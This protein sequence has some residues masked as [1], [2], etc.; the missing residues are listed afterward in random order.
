M[1]TGVTFSASVLS[2]TPAN[3]T[4]ANYPIQFTAANGVGSNHVQNFNLTVNDAV[5]LAAPNNLIAWYPGEGDATD[6]KGGL[7]GSALGGAGFAAGK[8]GQGFTFNGTT[9]VV[10]VPNNAAWNFG[11][12]AF[13]LETWVKFN[14]ISGT[15]ILVAHDEGAGAV[16]KWIF[17]L[18]GGSLGF[19]LNGSV[20]VNITSDATFTP[21]LGQWYHVAVTRSGTTYKF[22]LDGT[23]NGTDRFDANTVPTAT[24]PLTLGKAEALAAL[25]GMLDEVQIF[26]RALSAGEIQSVYNASTKG[27]CF[28]A[29]QS[30]SAVSR[31]T[32]TGAGDFDVPLPLTGEPGVECRTGGL[33]NDHKIVVS[34]NNV[35]TAGNAS[36]SAGSVVGSPTFSG[37]ALTINLTGVPNAQQIT[38]SLSNVKDGFGQTLP[39]A[40]VG[41]NVL[42]GDTTANKAVTASDVS[43]IKAETSNPIG[44]G[45]FRTDV[46]LNGVINGS[47]LSM[48]KAASG[49][50]I[51]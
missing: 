36:V 42:L 34:F 38:L 11:A 2:G 33:T 8:V 19:H 25:N 22:Y 35:V 13:T 48:T 9:A 3:G 46:S 5:C 31:K 15:D 45:N 21:T 23:Q 1:P 28:A 32:H 37:S 40:S 12:N 20:V 4:A 14:A 43:Q 44:A 51:P 6:A 29:L 17:W 49:T 39:S 27:L 26:N 24:A 18:Q 10:Q 50:G 41:M 47:D 7:N 30:A 16:N